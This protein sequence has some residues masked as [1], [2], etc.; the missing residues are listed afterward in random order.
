MQGGG[1]LPYTEDE[2]HGLLDR[3]IVRQRAMGAM[4]AAVAGEGFCHDG[5]IKVSDPGWL[6]S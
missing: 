1:A 5:P 6:C 3:T 4:I 2:L